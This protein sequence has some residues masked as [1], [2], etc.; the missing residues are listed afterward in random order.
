MSSVGPTVVY[1]VC[2]TL[3]SLP[4]LIS[5]IVSFG[6]FALAAYGL[7][8]LFQQMKEGYG[9]SYDPRGMRDNLR[10]PKNRMAQA[11]S[12]GAPGGI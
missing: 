7:Y 9:D 10:P 8:V 4:A 1:R 12:G 11:L 3:L 2:M 5:S 6:L